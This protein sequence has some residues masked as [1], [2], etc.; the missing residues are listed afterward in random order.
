VNFAIC[1]P[2]RRECL[3]NHWQSSYRD[4][5]IH[6]SCIEGTGSS[7]IQLVPLPIMVQGK[8]VNEMSNGTNKYQQS[9]MAFPRNNIA[10]SRGAGAGKSDGKPQNGKSNM[11]QFYG[12]TLIS[13]RQCQFLPHRC[14]YLWYSQRSERAAAPTMGRR[15]RYSDRWLSRIRTN[16][17]V[18][19]CTLGSIRRE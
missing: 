11:V 1:L 15:W 10:E 8:K 2:Q 14:C 9:N 18:Y 4:R 16:F 19:R 13:S 12:R 3:L 5:L 7:K 17:E 6:D